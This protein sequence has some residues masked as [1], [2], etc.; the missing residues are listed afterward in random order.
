MEMYTT[1]GKTLLCPIVNY[2]VVV[3]FYSINCHCLILSLKYPQVFFPCLYTGR[4]L[5]FKTLL[6][7]KL[8]CLFYLFPFPF[9]ENLFPLKPPTILKAKQNKTALFRTLM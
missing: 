6:R 4:H 9:L 3:L 7:Y 1:L 5:N 8:F 2:T